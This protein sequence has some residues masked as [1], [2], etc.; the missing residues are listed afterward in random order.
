MGF[1]G[2]KWLEDKYGATKAKKVMDRKKNLGL[3]FGFTKFQSWSTRFTS[4]NAPSLKD[5]IEI[6]ETPANCFLYAHSVNAKAQNHMQFR[7]D[8]INM[9]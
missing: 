1:R 9:H 5:H 3:K 2:Q 7:T 4:S 8:Y 6:F